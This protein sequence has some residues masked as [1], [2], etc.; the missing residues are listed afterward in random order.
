LIKIEDSY[1]Q[2]GIYT[3]HPDLSGVVK[4]IYILKYG[5]GENIGYKKLIKN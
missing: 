5:S 2:P 4:G 3:Y 1:K